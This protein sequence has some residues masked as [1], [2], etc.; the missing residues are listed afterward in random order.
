MSQAKLG[1]DAEET[2]VRLQGII[3]ARRRRARNAAENNMYRRRISTQHWFHLLT[4]PELASKSP[5]K[6]V[7]IETQSVFTMWQGKD[8]PGT[9]NSYYMLEKM[10][11]LNGQAIGGEDQALVKEVVRE[12][13]TNEPSKSW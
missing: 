7:L 3:T 10:K 8:G 5:V 13:G 1:E 4:D 11:R 12:L 6:S 9:I 2:R